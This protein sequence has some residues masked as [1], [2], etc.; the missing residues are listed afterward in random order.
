M[1]QQQILFPDEAR[2]VAADTVH[3]L[4]SA[5]EPSHRA[6]YIYPDGSYPRPIVMPDGALLRR[7][8][9]PVSLPRPSSDAVFPG[10][11][12]RRGLPDPLRWVSYAVEA[13]AAARGPALHR[14]DG[15]TPDD[16]AAAGLGLLHYSDEAEA[17]VDDRR[18]AMRRWLFDPRRTRPQIVAVLAHAHR[19]GVWCLWAD[20]EPT[21][22]P[23]A[24]DTSSEP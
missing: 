15:W 12:L 18:S 10:P 22:D 19:I 9:R 13:A 24:G 16:L 11:W 7:L 14:D 1:L 17:W 8:A 21:D 20:S 6:T 5:Q 23:A 2:K 3:H 4:E